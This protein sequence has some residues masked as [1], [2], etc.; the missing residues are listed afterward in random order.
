MKQLVIIDRK[1]IFSTLKISNE[2]VIFSVNEAGCYEK[3]S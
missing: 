1:L 2:I 3:V